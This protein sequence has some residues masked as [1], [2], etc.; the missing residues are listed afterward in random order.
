MRVNPPSF[1][2]LAQGVSGQCSSAIEA[3]SGS[4]CDLLHDF[5]RTVKA[6]SRDSHWP[7]R[8]ESL[9][10]TG[11]E[12]AELVEIERLQLVQAE[13]G[14]VLTKTLDGLLR[15]PVA[16][17]ENAEVKVVSGALEGSNVN[18]VESLVTMIDLARRFE[19]QV[20]L[21]QSAEENRNSLNQVMRLN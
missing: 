10:P 6:S 13:P 16:L 11:G 20:K 1:G 8:R 15:S 5:L 4:T 2:Q 19:T 17:F 12:A 14:Q 3:V 18:V 9:R 21:M 7:F